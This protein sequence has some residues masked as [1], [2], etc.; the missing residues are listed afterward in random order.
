MSQSRLRPMT[1]AA[2]ADGV[3]LALGH[4]DRAA[5]AR[6]CARRASSSWTRGG[7]RVDHRVAVVGLLG[8]VLA[9]RGAHEPRLD[10]ELAQAQ[11]LVGVGTRSAGG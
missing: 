11:A 7:G 4:E 2:R 1:R 5:A 8:A 10:A 3:A 6:G 9:P